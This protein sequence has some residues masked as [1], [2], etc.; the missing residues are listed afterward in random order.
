MDHPM[1]Y[2]LRGVGVVIMA[3]ALLLCFRAVRWLFRSVMSGVRNVKELPRKAGSA[4]AVVVDTAKTVKDG[5]VDGYKK[6]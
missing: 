5:F 2:V 1:D 4:A 3:Y 6:R